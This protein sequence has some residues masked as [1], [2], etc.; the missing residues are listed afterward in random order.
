MT[1]I[2]LAAAITAA[3]LAATAAPAD[4]TLTQLEKSVARTLQQYG[5]DVDVRTLSPAELAIVNHIEGSQSSPADK[6][7]RI[8]SAIG[9]G[10]RL[11]DLFFN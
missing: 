1:H 7:A 3:F 6:M 5:I 9:N 11:R 4:Q 2:R 10:G 8:N